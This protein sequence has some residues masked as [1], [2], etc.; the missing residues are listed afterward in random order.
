M[1]ALYSYFK[2]ENSD[3]KI[4][5]ANLIKGIEQVYDLYLMILELLGDI[6]HQEM[7][8][9]EENRNKRL[10]KPEDINPNLKFVNNRILKLIS[11]SED[12]KKANESSKLSVKIDEDLVRRILNQFKKSDAY[13]SYINSPHSDLE[14][15][16]N[17]LIQL[18]SEELVENEVLTSVFEE[19][20]I[21]WSDDLHMS[22]HLVIKTIDHCTG[23]LNLVSLFKD[24]KD[25]KSFIIDLFKKTIQYRS[26][27]TAMIKEHVKNWELERIAEMDMLLMQMCVAEFLY[28]PNVPIK[29]SLNEYIDISKE[30][31]TPNSKVFINGILDKIVLQL[32]RSGGIIKEGRGLKEN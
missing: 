20:N 4:S 31:S 17:L 1:Q 7:M 6:H 12:L 29:A 23:K 2:N 22:Y 24:E 32:K 30:Y 11:E 27:F 14:E 15:D 16:K 18:I 13:T 21:H 25:D 26:D 19:K 28:L 5:E 10:P 8:I 9:M 3:L